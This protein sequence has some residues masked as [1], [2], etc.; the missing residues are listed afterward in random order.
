MMYHQKF[1][2]TEIESMLPY[3]REIYIMMLTD[4]LEKE[5]EEMEKVRRNR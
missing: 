4:Q 5:N 2:L 3:E 1:S